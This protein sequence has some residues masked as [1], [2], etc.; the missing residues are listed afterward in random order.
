MRS[1]DIP[2]WEIGGPQIMKALTAAKKNGVATRIMFNGNF[3]FGPDK[4]NFRFDQVYSVIDTLTA[5]GRRR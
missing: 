5:N 2:I 3:G 1:V 4:N